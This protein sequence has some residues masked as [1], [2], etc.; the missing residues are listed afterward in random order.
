MYGWEKNVRK[1]LVGKSPSKRPFGRRR[2]RRDGDITMDQKESEWER[3]EWIHMP[4][5]KTAG[6]LL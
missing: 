2:R 3:V 4:Q 1:I 5:Y 6:R